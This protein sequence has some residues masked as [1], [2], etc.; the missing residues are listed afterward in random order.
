MIEDVFKRDL[1]HY[2]VIMPQVSI[3]LAI[4][5]VLTIVAVRLFLTARNNRKAWPFLALLAAAALQALL[6][7]L[8]WDF[9]IQSV[10]LA[11]VVLACLLPPLAWISFRAFTAGRQQIV[12]QADSVLLLPAVLTVPALRIAPDAID[13]IVIATYL[14]FGI[15]FL[16]LAWRGE[17]A[18]VH[19]TLNGVVNLKR[20]LWLV[21][22][23]LLASPLIDL[24]ILLDVQRNGGLHI[25]AFVGFGNILWLISIGFSAL[26]SSGTI[27]DDGENDTAE[28]VNKDA[29]E[30]D[31]RI[32]AIV[33][34]KLSADGLAKDP[35]L[36]LNRLARRC[37]IPARQVS[38]A[39]N[40]VHGKSVSQFVNDVRI[41]EACRLLQEP[42]FSITQAIYESGFQTKSNFNR[43][44]LRV[45]GRTP[46]AWRS[47]QDVHHQ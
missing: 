16:R 13:I 8:R 31:H 17:S 41:K 34:I 29:D 24:L 37:T 39:I 12:S 7:S 26:W 14:G 10:R 46:S 19:A 47:A 3:A 20:A 28:T 22:F 42:N 35:N 2:A 43:E 27:P 5:A 33:E 9:G 45:T 38:R 21:T 15:A 30:E 23:T 44:F 4:C 40:R 32:A 18:L 36:T 11:Q 25:A 6:V 1:G